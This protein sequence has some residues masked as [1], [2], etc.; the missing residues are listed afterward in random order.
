MDKLSSKKLIWLK[1]NDFWNHILP[2]IQYYC[3]ILANEGTKNLLQMKQE[4]TIM[5]LK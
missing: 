5:E 3:F 2:H 4:L 1:K